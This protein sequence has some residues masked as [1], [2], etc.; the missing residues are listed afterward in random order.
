M[1]ILNV[2]CLA[3]QVIGPV[4]AKELVASFLNA[5]QWDVD[6][7]KKR[8]KKIEQIEEEFFK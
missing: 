1:Y 2:M 3:G 8:I 5:K 7:Y 6:R 4:L